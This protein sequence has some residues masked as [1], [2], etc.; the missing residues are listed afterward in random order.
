MPDIADILRGVAG[1]VFPPA[2]IF[3]L[4]KKQETIAQIE[5][6]KPSTQPQPESMLI[7]EPV[8]QINL[9]Q[10]LGFQYTAPGIFARH[11]TKKPQPIPPLTTIIEEPPIHTAQHTIQQSN[12]APDDTVTI[13]QEPS[14]IPWWTYA[15]PMFGLPGFAAMFSG[16]HQGTQPGTTTITGSAGQVLPLTQGLGGSAPGGDTDIFGTLSKG[17]QVAGVAI[18]ILIGIMLLTKVKGLFD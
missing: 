5:H 14:S 7:V 18:P 10:E 16:L 12:V 11:Q 9:A 6:D 17:L 13:T 2:N 3:N 1:A 8:E 15:A 4:M